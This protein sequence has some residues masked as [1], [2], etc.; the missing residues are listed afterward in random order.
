M[1]PIVIMSPDAWELDAHYPE[2]FEQPTFPTGSPIPISMAK[3]EGALI[4]F[5]SQT[6]GNLWK[7]VY[8]TMNSKIKQYWTY[9]HQYAVQNSLTN[10]EYYSW[11][12]FVEEISEV[13]L[14]EVT[15]IPPKKLIH[16][17]TI[18]LKRPISR[19]NCQRMSSERQLKQGNFR[20]PILCLRSHLWNSR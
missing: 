13:D 20:R 19:S 8:D 9:A 15:W 16:V 10:S 14:S 18:T 5:L 2:G 4:G 12:R 3:R 1:D 11:D 7:L 17:S 6:K